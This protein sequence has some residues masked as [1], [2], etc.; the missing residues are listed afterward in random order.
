MSAP[1]ELPADAESMK[2]LEKE[3]S[4]EAKSEEKKIQSA[5]KDMHKHE[6]SEAKASKV[7][8]YFLDSRPLL[9]FFSL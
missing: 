4:M 3:L 1:T 2:K 7:R 6:K 8:R 9:T 5:F